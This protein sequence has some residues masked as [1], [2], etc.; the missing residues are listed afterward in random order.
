MARIKTRNLITLLRRL[1]ISLEAGVD[2]VR[3]IEQE[4]E[5]GPT[6]QRRQLGK[7]R[8][9]LN[10]GHTLTE[11]MQACSSYFPPLV[12]NLVEVGE[13]TGCMDQ[14][15]IRLVEY[16]ESLADLQ[17]TFI[18]GIIM[19]GIQLA[20][21]IGIV[22]LLIWIMGMIGGSGLDGEPI[23]MLGF[24]LI[25]TPGLIKYLM[26]VGSVFL[27]AFLLYKAVSSG[28]AG[29]MLMPLILRIPVVGNCIL[30][31][32]VARFAWTLGLALEAGA[33]ARQSMR[34]ALNSTQNPHFMQHA[35]K[36]DDGILEGREMHEIL[37]ETKVF[38]D[39]FINT[40]AAAEL[41][42]THS[43]S[44]QQV[45]K[46]YDARARLSATALTALASMSIWAGVGALIIFLIFRLAMF[47]LNTIYGALDGLN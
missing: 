10:S 25:G 47:Y 45:S 23:D 43:A 26:I 39:E 2:I 40:L 22:G 9:L 14:V 1:A 17:R 12:L 19:P 28:Q 35:K 3:L 6:E 11:S 20:M 29:G 46:E 33:D 16:Y 4:S 42:G 15:M 31:F 8:Q 18:A 44:L 37:D 41:S 32:A 36:V 30:T 38:P 7:I 27:G 34:M 24:G 21:A 13:Q 5:R